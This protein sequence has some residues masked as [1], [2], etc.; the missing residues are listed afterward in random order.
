[1][2]IVIVQNIYIITVLRI[3]KKKET[4]DYNN[5]RNDHAK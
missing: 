1:M 3:A 5:N 4:R 2:A